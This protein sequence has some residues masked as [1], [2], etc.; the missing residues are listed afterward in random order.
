MYIETFVLTHWMAY[1]ACTHGHA[2]STFTEKQLLAAFYTHTSF[3]LQHRLFTELCKHHQTRVAERLCQLTKDSGLTKRSS[4]RH[5]FSE[6]SKPSINP[7][8]QLREN[9]GI[10]LG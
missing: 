5:A 4:V 1:S 3:F 10:T 8:S 2:L 7:L 9:P 6:G